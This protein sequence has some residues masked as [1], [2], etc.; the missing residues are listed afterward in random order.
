VRAPRELA[1]FFHEFPHKE[2]QPGVRDADAV[3]GAAVA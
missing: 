1:R 2:F 3:L